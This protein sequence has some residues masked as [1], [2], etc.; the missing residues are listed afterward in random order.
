MGH[1][2]RPAT[3]STKITSLLRPINMALYTLVHA[4]CDNSAIS[5][6]DTQNAYVRDVTTSDVNETNS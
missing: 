5:D 4:T 1:T 3:S 2:N 6:S